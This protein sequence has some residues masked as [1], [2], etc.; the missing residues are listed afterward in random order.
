VLSLLVAVV[1]PSCAAVHDDIQ[2]VKQRLLVQLWPAESAIQGVAAAAAGFQQALNASCYWPDINYYDQNRAVWLTINHLSR[3]TTMVQALSAPYSPSYNH[4]DL[5]KATVCALNVWLTRQWTNPNWWYQAIGVPQSISGIFVMLGTDRLD[6]LQV[7]QGVQLMLEAA[8]WSLP[9]GEATGANLIWELQVEIARGVSTQNTSAVIEGF[10]RAW[11]EVRV[12]NTS[13]MGIETDMSYHF[14][15]SQIMSGSYGCDSAGSLF[16]FWQLANGTQFDCSATTKNLMASWMVDGDS[17]MSIR[18]IFDFGV[19][20]RSVARISGYGVT[21]APAMLAAF[22][23]YSDREAE[24][25]SY[26]ARVEGGA[27][28]TQLVG[29]RHYYT[30][31]YVVHRR[32]GWSAALRMHSN[33][34]VASECDNSENLK[35]EHL[36][37]GVLNV[38][39]ADDVPTAGHEYLNIFPLLDWNSINGITVEHSTPVFIC[40]PAS[41]YSFPVIDR[42][43]VGGATDG[44]FGVAA[45]D[46]ATHNLTAH[47]S[48]MFM[49]SSIVAVATN[50]R[51]PT[52]ADIWTTLASRFLTGSVSVA[53]RN[54]SVA[55]LPDG[56]Y[57]MEASSVAYV[58]ADG[59]AWVPSLANLSSPATL[60]VSAWNRTGT[61]QSIGADSGTT[62]GRVLGLWLDHGAVLT[63]DSYAYVIVPNVTLADAAN[64][65]LP[66]SLGVIALDDGVHAVADSSLQVLSAVFWLPSSTVTACTMIDCAWN[67]TASVT[68]PSLMVLTEATGGNITISAS[69]PDAPGA[70]VSVIV[71]RQLQGPGCTTVDPGHTAFEFHLPA[72]P[73][74][75]GSTL[76]ITCSP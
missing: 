63:N 24:L 76:A 62:F 40:G 64:G 73:D 12:V 4:S 28:A 57:T 53:F 54:G 15:G 25:L 11:E 5:G 51:D 20:G 35:G 58:W 33:R 37:D 67:I 34:T 13:S 69:N 3:V 44:Q 41:G 10:A 56:N 21:P 49:D 26:A 32:P 75:Q 61:W 27:G 38:Y 50:I 2:I 31:D 7:Q 71:D 6:A 59:V 46:T 72:D 23:P 42:T 47:R 22:A 14:H 55:T 74:F 45:M 39:A 36:A 16:D 29:T 17:W 66:E 52:S 8:W 68:F 70:L 1:Y 19:V 48:W 18:S 43:F 60:G 9:F 30:S 65:L